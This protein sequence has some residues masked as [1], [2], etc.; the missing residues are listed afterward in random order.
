MNIDTLSIIAFYSALLF[1]FVKYKSKFTIQ[2]IIALYKTRL[3]LRMMNRLA[4]MNHTLLQAFATSGIIV[5]FL[6]MAAGFIFL[7]KETLK[8]LT[9]PE[10]V[11]PLVPLLPGISIPGVPV[12]SFWHWIIAIFISAVVHEFS[13][14]VIARFHNIPIKSSGFAFLGPILAA[15]VEPDDTIMN[16]K[17]PKQQLGVL[18][19]GPFS[20]ILLGIAFFLIF[21]FITAPFFLDSFTGSG[22]TVSTL[23]DDSPAY[24]A[25]IT[26]PFTLLKINDQETLNALQFVNATQ[27]IHPGNIVKLETDK[28]IFELAVA[29]NPGNKSQGFIGLSGFTQELAPAGKA[30][31]KPWLLGIITWANLLVMWL[32]VINIGIAIFNLLPFS[33]ADGGKM[34]LI[35]LQSVFPTRGK[36]LWRILQ[37]TTISLIVINLLPWVLKL[38]EWVFKMFVFVISLGL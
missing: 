19:A 4:R 38:L 15:F 33:P 32:F 23:I 14:G 7:L 29:E 25:N 24:E 10:T 8:F 9:V 22:I 30:E 18:A 2:G 21:N 13:H 37:I 35:A 20:N 27:D 6:G 31:G 12:L 17:Q 3:G 1:L 11:T 36:Q 5:G 34:A 28:G 16:H 26:V